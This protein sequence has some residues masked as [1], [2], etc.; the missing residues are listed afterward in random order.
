MRKMRIPVSFLVLALIFAEIAAFI[1]VGQAIG[2]LAT[3]SLVFLG[4]VGGLMLLR[5][6][7]VAAVARV[8]A[9]LA[10][11]GSPGRP[12]ADGAA[13]VLA[14]IL[15]IVPGFV[16]DAIGL[17]LLVPAVRGALWRRIAGAFGTRVH[18]RTAASQ[19]RPRPVIDL[20]PADY[21]QTGPDRRGGAQDSPWRQPD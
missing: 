16:T 20:D 14:A 1:L 13:Q 9:E 19:P 3:L 12:L 6:Q 21:G 17:A 18:V 2:V 7:G 11:G 8:R 5:R 4:M 10:A 15:I